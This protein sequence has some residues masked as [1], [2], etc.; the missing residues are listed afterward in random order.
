MLNNI[1][2]ANLIFKIK[3]YLKESKYLAL[4]KYNKVLK[5]VLNISLKDYKLYSLII[6]E[7]IPIK[8]L[9]R[10]ENS[11]ICINSNNN[12]LTTKNQSSIHI[13]FN[14][15]KEEIKRDYITKDDK[16]K[17]IKIIIEY[18]VKS[19][20]GL[21]TFCDCIEEVNFINFKR[22][23]IIDMREMFAFC[24]SLSKINLENVKTNNVKKMSQMFRSCLSL[25]EI[26]LSNL[27]LSNVTHINDMFSGCGNLKKINLKNID[28]SN[29][30]NMNNIFNGCTSL[31]YID[32][33]NLNTK[34]VTD[35]GYMYYRY[36][37]K[38][39]N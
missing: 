26:D 13:Y 17:K 34:N 3:T 9:K 16:V 6:I 11:F 1:C 14:E 5:K 36:K 12:N 25:T 8:Q 19:L 22:D 28:T 37:N 29:V 39:K 15:G 18:N 4:F 30:I 21:F 32:L 2:K 23:D 24:K 33:S 38:I 7:L 27:N 35:M 31:E 20:R 10:Q